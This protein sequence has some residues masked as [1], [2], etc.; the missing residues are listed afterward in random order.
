MVS[1]GL[2]TPTGTHPRKPGCKYVDIEKCDSTRHMRPPPKAF[3]LWRMA[4][5][6]RTTICKSENIFQRHHSSYFVVD[7]LTR[8][9]FL[10]RALRRRVFARLTP[11]TQRNL[12]TYY[13]PRASCG[14]VL[15]QAHVTTRAA[16]TGAWIPVQTVTLILRALGP[17]GPVR[18]RAGGGTGPSRP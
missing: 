4:Y 16:V 12:P 7:L 10:T 6:L 3:I 15:S 17:A 13:F 18:R 2:T 9:D 14:C 5:A 11:T 8:V 1:S